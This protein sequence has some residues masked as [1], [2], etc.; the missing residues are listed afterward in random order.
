MM[1]AN[2]RHAYISFDSAF[3]VEDSD[4]KYYTTYWKD[5]NLHR[6]AFVDRRSPEEI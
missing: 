1:K 4:D 5:R 3:T 6:E 2:G